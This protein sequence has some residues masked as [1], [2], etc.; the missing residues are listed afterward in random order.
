MVS[1]PLITFEK[2]SWKPMD[3]N[4]VRTATSLTLDHTRPRVCSSRTRSESGPAGNH[5][6]EGEAQCFKEH[7]QNE[8]DHM[9]LAV[10]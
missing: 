8:A 4:S 10:C 1:H 3:I 6:I 9:Q 5:D 2:F 7:F